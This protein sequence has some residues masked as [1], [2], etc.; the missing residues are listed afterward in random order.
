MD[1]NSARI[2][3]ID[4]NSMDGFFDFEKWMV[5]TDHTCFGEMRIQKP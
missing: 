3:W 4:M 1:G 5:E 2:C